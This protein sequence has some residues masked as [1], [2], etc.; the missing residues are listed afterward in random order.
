MKDNAFASG[1]AAALALAAVLV[2]IVGFG[3]ARPDVRP[4]GLMRDFNAFYCAGS[5]ML[6]HADPYRAEPLGGCERR[7][8]PAPLLTGARGLAMP[9]PLPP[10]ALV[11][12]VALAWLPYTAAVIVWAL[13]IVLAVA[14]A[15]YAVRRTTGLPMLPIVTALA[16]TD[17][18][19]SLCLGQVAPIAVAAIAVAA[20]LV[21]VGRDEGAA[22]AAAFAM[23]E[24]HVALPVC[25]A[26]FVW[27]ARTRLVLVTA[28]L[29]CAFLSFSLASIPTTFEYL[30]AV[31]P[32]HALSEVVNEKQFSLTYA[33][34]RFG[35]TD[36][37]AVRAGELWYVAMLACGVV[38]SR[39]VAKKTFDDAA[40]VTI[41]PALAL[42]GGPFVHI[43]Q[44][45]AALPAAF[46]LYRHAGARTR[47]YL[48]I[49]IAALAI[50]WMQFVNLGTIFVLLAPVAAA[51]LVATLVDR[52]PLAVAG[53]AVFAV[54]VVEELTFFIATGVG[55]ATPAL[56]AHYDPKALAE[57]SWTLY[58]RAIGTANARAFD[59]A[60][61]PTLFGL[62]TLVCAATMTVFRPTKNASARAVLVPAWKGAEASR[63]IA[64]R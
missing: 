8:K 5:A 48:G 15:A 56:V 12:F 3:A 6:H 62:T 50:P 64:T 24:P 51:V 21:S 54:L 32:A 43:I 27:R 53:A 19:A 42:V 45:A 46:V 1:R 11:P 26:L 17:G 16:L 34:H 40:I 35:A 60:K 20:M 18:Y 4:A 9:A 33:L 61:I 55:D 30:R 29:G 36:A 63:R 37:A 59:L 28:A 2:A 22:L 44:M 10:Y 47:R 13:C 31:I 14:V 7:P 39:I 57:A 38:L 23:I 58:V 49:G 25:L 41:P 52:R